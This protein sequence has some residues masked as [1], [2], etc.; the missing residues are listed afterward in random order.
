[1]VSLGMACAANAQDCGPTLKRELL[2]RKAADQAARESLTADPS[3]QEASDATLRV[4]ADNTAYMRRVLAKCG[5][6]KRS[7][8]GPDAARAAWLLA[9]HADMDPEFQV[10]AARQLKYAVHGG[11]ADAL[12]LAVLVDRNRRLNDQPQ[13]YGMQHYST[14]DASI[15]FYDIVTPGQLDQRRKRIGLPPFFCWISDVSRQNKGAPVH[16]PEGVLF[17]PSSCDNEPR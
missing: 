5:W 17:Q 15:R 12:D 14:A 1:M 6:P 7:I 4:D 2:E 16:W 10:L 9:Q 13:V 3:S 11:E 8:V